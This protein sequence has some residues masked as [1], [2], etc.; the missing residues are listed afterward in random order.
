GELDE[1]VVEELAA[2]KTVDG[3]VDWIVARAPRTAQPGADGPAAPAGGPIP[4]G[5]VPAVSAQP[6]VLAGP[7]ARG[8]VLDAVIEVIGSQTGYPAEMLEPGLDLEADLSI[9]S[10]KR[11][12]ILGELAGR[13]GLAGAEGGELDESVVEELAA[14]KTV[15][16]I[17]DWIVAHGGGSAGAA[18]TAAAVTPPAGV[19][20]PGAVPAQP[21]PA[22]FGTPFQA[23]PGPSAAPPSGNGS[24]HN[25][26]AHNGSPSNGLAGGGSSQHGAHVPSRAVAPPALA[27]LDAG[28]RPVGRGVVLDAVV[29]VIGSQTGYPAEMLEPGLDLEADLSIDSI[30]RTEILGE[31]AGRL[32]LAGAEGGELDESVVEELAAIK[33]VDGIVDWIVAHTSGAAAN[34][35][36]AP[37]DATGAASTRIPLRRFVVEP[38]PLPAAPSVAEA[39]ARLGAARPD[40]TGPLAGGRFAVVEGGLGVGLELADLLEQAGAAVRLLDAGAPD[41]A[42][43]VASGVAADGLLWVAALDAGTGSAAELPGAFGALKAAVLG[44][45]A[46]GGGGGTRRLV[47]ASGLGGDFGR[48]AAAGVDPGP[49]A[50]A[51]FAGLART[52]AHE[53]PDV[54]VRV[55]DVDP[56]DA[57]R[58]IAE[59][60][61]TEML[62][63]DAPLVVGHRDGIRAALRVVPVELAAPETAGLETAGL[64][65][66]SVV[67]LT[68]GARGITA[69]LAMEIARRSGAHVELVGRT[70]PPAAPEDPA[71]AGA[72][73]APALRR[74]LIATGMRKPAEIEAR[75]ARLLAEREVRATLAELD[76]VAA[77]VRYHAVDVRDAAAVRAVVADVYARHGRLDGVVHG[78]GVLE[79]RLVRDKTPESFARVYSTK[80]DGARALLGALRRDRCVRETGSAAPGGPDLGGPGFVVLFGSVAG[81]FGNRGQVD[82]AAANDTLDALAHAHAGVFRT[83]RQT[84]LP[85]SAEP[86]GAPGRVVS[87]DWGPWRAEGG[88]MVSAEL[89]REYARRGIGLIEPAEGVAALL[90]ELSSP[91]ASGTQG[92]AQVVYLCGEADALHG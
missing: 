85:G 64:G 84:A 18:G 6:P 82:Y 33:T 53:L 67:L 34:A 81:V 7:P 60:L 44:P 63:S 36:E 12:E 9:D 46:A 15:D 48:H 79:D 89:E 86:A 62:A 47:L 4:A 49:A 21:T 14:I 31:L 26:A 20:P 52:L 35:A 80:V 40:G 42:D 58:R 90:H 59:S 41:L 75:L 17:V 3:I 27:T 69:L 19:L 39:L 74:A 8:V 66:D 73:D 38:V 45:R 55:V 88:G 28:P 77:G 54:A 23:G 83:Y 5:A 50:G 10:I 70:P 72:L 29:E 24:S 25:G 92:P 1:S 71:T 11:T 61:L 43:Q 37:Q 78:A 16:G 56:K 51:G 32:G 65:P 2:I 22:R 68:G 76:R 57:P 13:L 87:V 30:K 91:H